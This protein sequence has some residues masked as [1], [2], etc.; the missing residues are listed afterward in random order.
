[1]ITSFINRLSSVNWRGVFFIVF[2]FLCV[3]CSSS[4]SESIDSF[5]EF[6]RAV[7]FVV[8]IHF[9][10]SLLETVISIGPI[11]EVL[12]YVVMALFIIP[13]GFLMNL[14][15]LAVA[16]GVEFIIAAIFTG[17]FCSLDDLS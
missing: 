1:M 7:L 11:T 8:V 5:D 2:L 13:F 14:V 4:G 16:R 6:F 9:I 10:Y 3:S 15:I 12:F 17:S